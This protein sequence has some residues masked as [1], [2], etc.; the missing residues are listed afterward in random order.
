[1]RVW[2]LLWGWDTDLC[3]MV[4]E[5]SVLS[6]KQMQLFRFLSLC[7]LFTDLLIKPIFR[8]T[9]HPH[10]QNC[11][12]ARPRFAFHKKGTPSLGNQ[13]G[14]G[15]LPSTCTVLPCFSLAS[16]DWRDFKTSGRPS[17]KKNQRKLSDSSMIYTYTLKY[18]PP[19]FRRSPSSR[20]KMATLHFLMLM[21][22]VDFM[23]RKCLWHRTSF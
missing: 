5:V 18:I 1:M 6:P 22:K 17:S 8:M 4:F 11:I 7:M 15:L 10:H 19:H 21:R 20:E 23:V 12:R 9:D 3:G 16:Q 13:H 2:F 14:H